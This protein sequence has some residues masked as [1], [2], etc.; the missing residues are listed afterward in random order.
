MPASTE[1]T[2]A[3]V[4]TSASMQA[5]LAEQVIRAL[6]ALWFPFIWSGDF[7]ATRA[8]AARSTVIADVAHAKA[9]RIMRAHMLAAL[10]DLDALPPVLPPVEDIYPRSGRPMIEV[11]ERPARRYEHAIRS[12]KTPEQ[13]AKIM[14]EQIVTI[15][16]TDLA[17]VKRDEAARVIE[18]APAK[19]IGYR[20]VIHPELSQSGA[21]GLCVVAADRFYTRGDLQELHDNCKCESLP[22]TADNDPGLRLNEDDLKA[23]YG[24]AGSNR[25]ENL[26]R[27]RVQTVEH[28]ELG[29]IL[30]RDGNDFK[31]WD[32][33][34]RQTKRKS[35]RAT[36]YE[37]P[38][39]TLNEVNWSVMKASSE[40]SIARLE[41]AEADG[42]NMV[43]MAG[44]GRLTRVKNIAKA[45]EYHEGLI[46]R[47]NMHLAA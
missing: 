3:L 46:A 42:T 27:I 1:A 33:V 29:P 28:G 39:K 16:E 43:D 19:I 14:Q 38:T 6:F 12:G 9:R 44:T 22:L 8:L 37:R 7:E 30:V 47:A 13:A 26:K 36:P 5:S 45:I 23:L 15:V 32:R 35:T 31:T 11:Y 24:A 10:R 20:R 4:R 41:A 34:N 2:R 17:A 21:C 40:R 25:M 18:A